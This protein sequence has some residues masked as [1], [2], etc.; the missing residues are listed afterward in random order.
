MTATKNNEVATINYEVNGENVKLSPALVKQYLVNGN[1]NVSDQEVVMF[2]QLC[3]YQKLNPFLN[4]AYLVKFGN[5]PASIIT[6]KEAF[7]K[8]AENNKHYKGFKAG[9][10]VARGDEMK[11]IDGAIKMPKDVLIG[12]WAEVYR[13]D[14]DEPIHVEISLDEFSKGQ[15]TWKQMPMNMIRKT[16]LVNALREAFP[17]SLGAMYTEDDKQP[18]RE[19]DAQE[20][21]SDDDKQSTLN[22]LI[23]DDKTALSKPK[24]NKT[25]KNAQGVKSEE[26]DVDKLSEDIDNNKEQETKEVEQDDNTSDS[27]Q[28]EEEQQGSLFDQI[29][30]IN[31]R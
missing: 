27:N 1:G 4:E 29:D 15:A 20:V 25:A 10:V 13:D 17:E 19:V 6:S 12:A 16:A 8:R 11:H 28:P 24:K 26:L 18:M 31:G 2:M 22:D 7:M 5:Q 3:R 23:S 21:R 14:R 9:I 30:A